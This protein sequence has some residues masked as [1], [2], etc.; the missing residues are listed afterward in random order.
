MVSILIDPFLCKE[1]SNLDIL[2]DRKMLI[3]I[4]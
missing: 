2:L 3:D 1:T 4:K